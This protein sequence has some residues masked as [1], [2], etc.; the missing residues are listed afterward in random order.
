VT[1][2]FHWPINFQLSQFVLGFL[3]LV[4]VQEST[5]TSDLS[6]LT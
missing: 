2:H 3:S 1:F 4:T 5:T 6:I